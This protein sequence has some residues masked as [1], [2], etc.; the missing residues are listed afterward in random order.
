MAGIIPVAPADPYSPTVEEWSA[1]MQSIAEAAKNKA[2]ISV[3]IEDASGSPS[4]DWRIPG[5]WFAVSPRYSI[6]PPIVTPPPPPTPTYELLYVTS[7]T[8]L[9]VRKSPSVTAE[10]IGSLA[11]GVQAMVTGSTPADGYT[12]GQLQ[13][14]GYVAREFLSKIQPPL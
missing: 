12:W 13:S 6:T 8:G 7:S 2:I 10:Q 3:V 9:K 5:E 14:G 11:Y 1:F 4:R